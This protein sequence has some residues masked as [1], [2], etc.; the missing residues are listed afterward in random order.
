M[1]LIISICPNPNIPDVIS[2]I[3]QKVSSMILWNPFYSQHDIMRIMNAYF[4]I[5]KQNKYSINRLHVF[6]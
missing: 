2:F 6:Y 4:K 5:E 3:I 1:C